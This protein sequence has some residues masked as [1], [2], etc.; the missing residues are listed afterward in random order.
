M[1]SERS[2]F[3][4]TLFRK[5]LTRSW[6]LWGSVTAAGL[7]LPLYFI[8]AVISHGHISLSRADFMAVLYQAV[9]TFLPAITACYALLVAMFV[10]SYLHNTRAV[11]M[12]HSLA[13]SR[14]GL[15]VTNTLSGL[16]MLLIPYV[17]LGVFFCIIGVMFGAL[18]V[19][20]LCL[21]VGAVL[22]ETILFFGLATFCT[23]ITGN[24]FA[25][26]GYY[27]LFN[28]IVPVVD[29]L[30]RNLTAMF[31]FGYGTTLGDTSLLFAP[32]LG[33]YQNVSVNHIAPVVSSPGSPE[34]QLA[35]E[36][37][38]SIVVYGLVG[39]L[40]LVAAWALYR[41]RRSESAGDIVTFRPLR[42]VFRFGV[43]FLSSLTLGQ[44]LYVIFWESLFA[45]TVQA[46]PMGL[47][48]AIA[49][50]VGYYAASMLLEKSLRVFK[51]SAV[52]VAVACIVPFALSLFI[53]YDG[54]GLERRVPAAQDVDTV[55]IYGS[56]DLFSSSEQ[57]PALTEHVIALHQAIVDDA[58][59]VQNILA[60]NS[61]AEE[62]TSYRYLYLTYTLKNGSTLERSY[63]IPLR[64]SRLSDAATYDSK[65]YALLNDPDCLT[66]EV[67]LP[68]GAEL[69][70]MSLRG[71]SYL[72]ESYQYFDGSETS[73][74]AIYQAL[75]R[76]AREGNFYI[77]HYVYDWFTA[78]DDEDI[79]QLEDS[80]DTA[81]YFD[82][83]V[84]L[85]FYYRYQD[86]MFS[87]SG[88]NLIDL[89]LYPT[90]THTLNALLGYGWIT[91]EDIEGWYFAETE[92]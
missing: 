62:E 1:L 2:F 67:S 22:L 11:S 76:D 73:Y 81:L 70:S 54:M 59:Y 58:D 79:E 36:G 42:P 83:S 57:F 13:I 55:Q 25:V 77:Y 43:A 64:R 65:F 46:I 75:L 10:W 14:T 28:F 66:A 82:S 34:D 8:L 71:Y 51:G 3:N 38:G 23:M 49:A 90:M 91:P 48:A 19:G 53:A 85:T 80:N 27:L 5:N 31:I 87:S 50:A 56:I 15:F 68:E 69:Q 33:L 6:P 74:D 40:L 29:L 84:T 24:I 30:I 9:A 86:G 21:T 16:A 18:D 39:L 12:M 78:K 41:I 35:L 32:V 44:L 60:G 63:S 20:A 52:G 26:A 88:V 4:P 37:F 7:L 92:E 47:C 72:T 89:D 61:Y 17:P 45:G